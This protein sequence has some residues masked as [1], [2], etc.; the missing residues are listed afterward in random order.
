[1]LSRLSLAAALLFSASAA[2]AASAGTT[3]FE[4]FRTDG[5][6]RNSAL[7]GSQIAVGGDLHNLFSNPAGLTG[8]ERPLGGVG[9]FKHVLDINSG[10]LAYARPLAGRGVFAAG[11]TYFDY[12]KFDKASENGQKLGDFGA[13]DI[14]LTVSGARLMRPELAAGVSLK[15]LNSTI[16]SYSASALAADFGLLYHTGY[17]NW[18]VGAGIYNVGFATSAYLSEK[19]KLPTAYRLGFAVPLEHLPVR[20]TLAGEYSS[21]ESIRGSGGLEL[22]FHPAVQGRLG[23]STL[24]VD[25]RVGTDRDALAGFSAGLGL[26]LKRITVDYALTSQGEVGYLNRFTISAPIGKA[27]AN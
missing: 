8:I 24:G 16:D 19:D 5:S 18:D 4:L 13:S 23:Y 2:L 20:V 27:H 9:F 7:A 25:Q 10:N 1:M 6:A 15:Y 21:E 17:E 14:L 11:L 12:G 22:T 26:R 3:G